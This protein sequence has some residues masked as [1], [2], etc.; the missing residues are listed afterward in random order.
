MSPWIHTKACISIHVFPSFGVVSAPAIF[1]RLMDTLLRG[2]PRV[3][4]CIDDILVTG[5]SEEEHLCNL[6]EVFKQ[7][8]EHGFGL[9]KPK[10]SFMAK[11]VEYLGHQVDQHGIRA[12]PNKV[13]PLRMF[14][15]Y[16]RFSGYS[17]IMWN[18]FETS[19]PSSTLSISCWKTSKRG[20]RAR[21]VL[22]LSS[23]PK[24]NWSLQVCWYWYPKL[25]ITMAGDASAYGIGAVT[26]TF[27]DG[28]ERPISFASRT[29]TPSEQ[30]CTQLE[31]E[32]LSLVY[33]VKKFHQYLYGRPFTLVTHHKPLTVIFGSKKGI[34]SLAAARLQR[35][36]LLLSAYSYKSNLNP[37]KTMVMQ[38]GCPDYLD[39]SNS[40]SESWFS[41][42]I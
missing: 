28:S 11:S 41:K 15:S 31:K 18:L 17:I 33:G 5:T 19:Q 9:K 36:A 6:A 34:P 21:N 22:T 39:H 3:I 8:Q 40:R 29:L 30:N 16:D 7:L 37:V 12:L 10:C 35:W 14:K 38:M 32:A 26:H 2:I 27:P 25:P 42:C 20:N 4:C 23:L 24:I 1:Q 13:K